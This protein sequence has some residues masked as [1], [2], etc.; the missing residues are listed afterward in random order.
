MEHA[1]IRHLPL[2]LAAAL[3][4]GSRSAGG[5]EPQPPCPRSSSIKL[6]AGSRSAGGAEPQ[7]AHM[8]FI[9]LKDRCPEARQK[10]V[11]S[12][13]EHLTGHEGTVSFSVG[14]IAD[15]VDVLE[16]ISDRDFDVAL[17]LFFGKQG[18]NRGRTE[19]RAPP[20]IHRGEQGNVV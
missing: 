1:I 7:R 3:G 10:L 6:D 11:A 12:C 19:E 17:H 5:A 20:E 2:V 14:T 13:H 16:L 15:A 18:G 9:T 4:A 8:G